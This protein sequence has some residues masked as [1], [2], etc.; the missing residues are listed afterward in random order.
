MKM[1]EKIISFV[2]QCIRVLKIMKKPSLEEIKLTIKITL[3][4]M[5]IIGAIGYLI[6]AIFVLL[7]NYGII[8]M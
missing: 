7:S 8:R 1:K 6:F 5:T 3:L 2:N 4:G